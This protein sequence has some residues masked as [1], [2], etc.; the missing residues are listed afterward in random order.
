MSSSYHPSRP[1]SGHVRRTAPRST[2]QRHS[3]SQR[4][5]SPSAAE[6]KSLIAYSRKLKDESQRAYMRSYFKR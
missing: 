4:R 5:N 3:V 1:V 2:F 6:L